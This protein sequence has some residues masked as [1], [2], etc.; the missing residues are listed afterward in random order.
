MVVIFIIFTEITV[1]LV[2]YNWSL[3]NNNNNNHKNTEIWWVQ[4]YKMGTIKQI[5]IKNLTYYF[6]KNIIDLQNFDAKLL[7]VDKKSYKD[8]GIY[9]IGYVTKKKIDDYMNIN[10]VNPLYL[11]ITSSNGYIEEKDANKYLIFD[12]TDKNKELLKKYND[13]FNGIRDKIKKINSN[14]CDYEKYYMRIKFNSNDDLSWNKSLKL[15]LMTITI[16]CVFEEN[17]K[18][19]PQVFLDDTLYEL[20]V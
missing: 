10:S 12:P 16:R 8:I 6:N 2:Y 1:Y 17:G 5:N 3:I 9:N 15:H 19:C 13:A 11:G 20:N 18:V 14:E 4:L 7:S